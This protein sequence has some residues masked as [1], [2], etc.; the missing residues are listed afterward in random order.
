MLDPGTLTPRLGL[1]LLLFS[2][3]ASVIWRTRKSPETLSHTSLCSENKPK[4]VSFC[5][6][7][8][9]PPQPSVGWGQLG[10]RILGHFGFSPE[11]LSQPEAFS[12]N[13]FIKRKAHRPRASAVV[14]PPS[15]E[16]SKPSAHWH[17]EGAHHCAYGGRISHRPC[18]APPAVC[19]LYARR[20]VALVLTA[21]LVPGT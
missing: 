14:L 13:V 2:E 3:Q 4:P 1:H 6:P 11:C 8:L 15:S 18:L 21:P 7:P 9:F 5:T 17:P 16:V 12:T 20:L 10:C 19:E